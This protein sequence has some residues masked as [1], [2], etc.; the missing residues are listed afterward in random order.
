MI[1]LYKPIEN[2]L[3]Y[4]ETWDKDEKTAMIH[5]GLLGNLDKT[6]K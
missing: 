1:K 3:H 6:K 5:W 4:W 2:K